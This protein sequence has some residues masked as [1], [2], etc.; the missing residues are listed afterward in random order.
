MDERYYIDKRSGCIAVRD[1]NIACDS[2][3][4]H[5]DLPG[6]V[7]FKMGIRE[8][9]IRCLCC[10]QIVPSYPVVTPELE[11]E[12]QEICDKLNKEK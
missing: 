8:R 12:A 11:T 2:P 7:W 6:V 3:G 4:L 1:R 5:D 10:G 9:D